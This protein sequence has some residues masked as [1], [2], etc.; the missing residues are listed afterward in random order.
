MRCR[1][2]I[3]GLGINE[4]KEVRKPD[5][6]VGVTGDGVEVIFHTL[7]FSDQ[8]TLI[9]AIILAINR[10]CK[11]P[12]AQGL[13]YSLLRSVKTMSKPNSNSAATWISGSV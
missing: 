3:I 8:V 13:L 6:F 9:N 4:G 5:S 11:P 7:R 12:R 10:H 1:R 2:V